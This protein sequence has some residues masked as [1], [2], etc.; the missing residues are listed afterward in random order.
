MRIGARQKPHIHALL[1][2]RIVR[3]YPVAGTK[4]HRHFLILVGFAYVL[5]VLRFAIECSLNILHILGKE[6]EL[7]LLSTSGTPVEK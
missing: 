3:Y 4:C 5:F 2:R 1:S 7:S 6:S